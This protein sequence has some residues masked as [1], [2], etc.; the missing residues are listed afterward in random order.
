MTDILQ[1]VLNDRNDEKKLYYFKKILPIIIIFALI[2]VLFMIFRN[3]HED[4]IVKNNQ[5]TGDILV[6][7]IS[8]MDNDQALSTKSLEY[9]AETSDNKIGAL[10]IIERIAFEIKQNNLSEAK[11]LLKKII[12]NKNY[13]ELTSAY[14]RLIWLSL[15]IDEPNLSKSNISETEEYLNYFDD[16]KPFFGTATIIKA[17]WYIKNDS[18]DLAK[19]LLKKLIHLEDSTQIVK[20]QAKAL[21][22]N[23]Q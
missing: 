21:L 1:E 3:W 2:V 16:N 4:K 22:S 11:N 18:N 6:K 12:N 14:A 8:L 9:L 5:R 23:L 20:E 15:I 10:A 13:D 19:N 7:S 17:I